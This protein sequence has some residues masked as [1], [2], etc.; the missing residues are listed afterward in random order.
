[1]TQHRKFFLGFIGIIAVIVMAYTAG[2]EDGAT[3]RDSQ[4][5][6]QAKCS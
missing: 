3:G 2:H 4:L 5:L 1:M 6:A